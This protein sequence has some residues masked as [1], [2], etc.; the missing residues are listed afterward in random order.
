MLRVLP[1]ANYLNFSSCTQRNVLCACVGWKR[2]AH[3][4]MYEDSYSSGLDVEVVIAGDGKIPHPA[5]V[6]AGDVPADYHRDATRK[7]TQAGADFE[8]RGLDPPAGCGIPE[9]MAA[10][11][12]DGLGTSLRL[13]LQLVEVGVVVD[14]YCGC[15]L[16]LGLAGPGVSGHYILA[17][18]EL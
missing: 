16:S 11:G 9:E 4:V 18:P 6:V 7:G 10:G 5:V 8:G 13:D 2:T 17:S 3:N 15:R 14:Q 1:V 12:V